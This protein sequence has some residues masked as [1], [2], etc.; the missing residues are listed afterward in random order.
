MTVHPYERAM[1]LV[2]LL[3]NSIHHGFPVVDPVTKK[4]LGLIRRDQIAA[5]LECGVFE[6]GMSGRD[7]IAAPET[8]HTTTST[9]LWSSP[10]STHAVGLP[11]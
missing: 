2:E 4:C 3:D 8:C 5:L 6:K 9:P 1:D 11:Y 10:K 7:E